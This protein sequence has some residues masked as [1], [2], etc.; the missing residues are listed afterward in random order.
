M[1]P[2]EFKQ[3]RHKLGLSLSGLAK[4]LDTDPRTIRKWEATTGTNCRNPNPI[5]CQVL[6]WLASGEL[7][8][9][10]QGD[11]K[12]PSSIGVSPEKK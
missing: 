4:I 8:L 11:A 12:H 10:D 6:R 1:T 2:Q 7:N 9:R 3:A 5:A